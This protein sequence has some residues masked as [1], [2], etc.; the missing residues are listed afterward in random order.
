MH[1]S[2]V[3][4]TQQKHALN[5]A[6]QSC[7]SACQTSALQLSQHFSH[8]YHVLWVV[9][10]QGVSKCSLLRDHYRTLADPC[11]DI[12]PIC[13]L[14]VDHQK[15]K[16]NSLCLLCD[17]VNIMGKIWILTKTVSG[18]SISPPNTVSFSRY[19]ICMS[20]K[21]CMQLWGIQN[22]G[23]DE[24]VH[25]HDNWCPMHIEV[26]SLPLWW[27]RPHCIG[28]N[29]KHNQHAAEVE[30]QPAVWVSVTIRDKCFETPVFWTCTLDFLPTR[31]P[32][33]FTPK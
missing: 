27:L 33:H 15:N 22:S 20:N 11:L 31:P 9:K 6:K 13:Y 26:Q 21:V 16:I 28:H 5:G 10:Y 7:Q 29:S 17:L 30:I 1:S 24:R 18:L 23:R 19:N 4:G 14:I 25:L 3:T 12:P 32:I 2:H 8:Y